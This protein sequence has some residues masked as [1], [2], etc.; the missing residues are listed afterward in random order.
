MDVLLRSTQQML[1]EY[2]GQDLFDLSNS[3]IQKEFG[4]HEGGRLISQLKLMKT[5]AS[6]IIPL[7][8]PLLLRSTR[9]NTPIKTVCVT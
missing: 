3:A 4:S 7:D 8:G 6:V 5:S 2:R 1:R 9:S